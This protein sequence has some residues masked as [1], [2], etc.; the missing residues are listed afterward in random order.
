[1]TSSS[2]ASPVHV[3]QFPS[4]PYSAF[5][6]YRRPFVPNSPEALQMECSTSSPLT[7]PPAPPQINTLAISRSSSGIASAE[8]SSPRKT[9]QHHGNHHH[10]AT[11]ARD[12]LKTTTS[13]TPS[14]SENVILEPR[15][16]PIIT[17]VS[18]Q[19]YFNLKIF[20]LAFRP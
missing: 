3:L 11:V 5:S 16:N 13:T 6:L 14:N 1:M 12:P 20:L 8:Q 15:P 19:L 4:P 2:G 10:H 18:F 7:A 17:H 9:H